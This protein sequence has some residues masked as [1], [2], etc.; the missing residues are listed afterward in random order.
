MKLLYARVFFPGDGDYESRL[1]NEVL[2]LPKE[3][4]G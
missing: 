4:L 1:H 3:D 2:G